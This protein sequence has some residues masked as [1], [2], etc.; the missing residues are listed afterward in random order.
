[1]NLAEADSNGRVYVQK[2]IF[3]RVYSNSEITLREKLVSHSYTY[4]FSVIGSV[5][6]FWAE[7][8]MRELTLDTCRHVRYVRACNRW[9]T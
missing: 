2:K 6:E 4:D 8:Y 7:L 5:K 1:M 9:R 3:G